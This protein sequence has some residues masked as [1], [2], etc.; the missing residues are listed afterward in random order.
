VQLRSGLALCAIADG[1]LEDAEAEL[2]RI[3]AVDDGEVFGGL[4]VRRIGAAELAL[5]RGDHRGGLRAYRECA[6][7]VSQLRIPGVPPTGHE[8]WVV[9]GES[10]ALTA[11]AVYAADGDVALGSEL[12][13]SC[14][15]RTLRLVDP[16]D[17]DVD[18][19]VVG[20]ALH[21]LGAWGLLRDATSVE[22]A[23]RLLALAERL[24]YNRAIPTMARERIEAVAEQRLDRE[25]R[26]LL[27]G[28]GDRRPRDLLDDAR[29]LV[30]RIGGQRF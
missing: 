7:T 25:L 27:A 21:G 28:Y 24:A 8:P 5:A 18:C 10:T 4:A 14:L 13:A 15:E 9:F 30:A 29:Q 22:D 6:A 19:P 1:R 12:F 26:P 23:L 17:P 3:A 11:H 16:A 20:M 2:Q